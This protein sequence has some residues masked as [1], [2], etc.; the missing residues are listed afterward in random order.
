V[1][2]EIKNKNLSPLSI[3]KRINFHL[4]SNRKRDIKVVLFLSIL[5]SISE[6]ISIAMLIPFVSFFVNPDNY[7]FN[8]LFNFFFNFLN[9]TNPKNIFALVSFSFIF[10]VLLSGFIRVKHIKYSNLLSENITSDFRIRIFQFLINQDF[11]YYFKH[12]SNELMSSL[13]Q[14]TGAFTSKVLASI[15][16]IN[17]I[18]ISSSI[19]VILIINEPFYTPLIIFSILSFF[20][21]IFKIKTA[22]ILEKG[23]SININ[24]NF[25]INI[26]QNTIGYL[27]E[28]IIYNLRNFFLLTLSN[29]SRKIAV[30]GA[31]VKTIALSPRIYLET[32]VITFV[33]L[34]VYFS[35]L[36]ERSV[37]ANIS[38][39]AILAFGAQKCLPLINGLYN[40]SIN[41]K[42]ATPIVNNFLDILEEGNVNKI[43]HSEC[44]VLKFEK[45]IKLKNLSFKYNENLPNILNK[46][47]FD[48]AKGEKVA[49][50]GQT[51]SG[52]ST[53]AHII[54]GLVNP[55]EGHIYIDET[56]IDLENLKNWQKNISIVPQIVFLND[57]T[58]LENIAIGIDVNSIDLKKAK[59]SAR[60]AYID[61]F[62][63]SLPNKYEEKV[64]ERGVRL[65]GGQRQRIGI[66]RALYRNAKLIILDEPTNALDPKKESLVMNSITKL[67]KDIT[68]IMISHSNTSLKYFDKIIDLD[69]LK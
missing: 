11:K 57:A 34:V 43:E 37:E 19:G 24:Q 8:N 52:K 21:I 62:I 4:D 40:H 16:I 45:S 30:S 44:A 33:V 63:E 29:V 9:I 7:M 31:I 56:L 22:T 6:S 35:D 20:Y 66:A 27:P 38:Y 10:I 58:V 69:K 54:S 13:S 17:S 59:N 5:S 2:T 14:K 42:A 23:Q 26:F 47:S 55:S 64:G 67:N 12:G 28:V 46:L 51:G 1:S 41:F 68:L 18:L 25:M 65:S 50:K 60:L 39:L 49:I 3:L 36:S 15:N 48:I 32:F 61:T 53:L